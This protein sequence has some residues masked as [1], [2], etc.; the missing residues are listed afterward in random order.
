MPIHFQKSRK[1]AIA[2]QVA[3]KATMNEIQKMIN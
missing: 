2:G 1:I 3:N